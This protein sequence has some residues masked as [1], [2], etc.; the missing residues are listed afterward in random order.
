M[1]T[2]TR[3]FFHAAR[4]RNADAGG[5]EGSG[6]APL[7]VSIGELA[8][9][10]NSPGYQAKLAAE[11]KAAAAAKSGQDARAPGN[12]GILPAGNGVDPDAA[13]ADD[14]I[15]ANPG[16]QITGESDA[17]AAGEPPAL[18]VETPAQ[19]LA[20][21]EAE[22]K[23]LE[24]GEAAAETDPVLAKIT[25]LEAEV[26]ALKAGKPV[27]E[28]T[29]PSAPAQGRFKSDAEI[30]AHEDKLYYTLD[31]AE[32]HADGFEGKD[33]K[34]NPLSYTAEQI[35]A[36]AREAKRELRALPAE[37][38]ALATT[39]AIGAANRAKYPTHFN[40]AHPD[41]KAVAALFLERPAIKG[42]HELAAQI[43]AGRKAVK[44]APAAA[45][46]KTTVPPKVTAPVSAGS[47]ARPA[48]TKPGKAVVDLDK[49]R[50]GQGGLG[51]LVM[52]SMRRRTA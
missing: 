6:D 22:K 23:A 13:G 34:G 21:L 1:N 26:A 3:F 29:V 52:Q 42:D 36:W 44:G 19:K 14:D 28:S 15:E 37:R 30:K 4:L 49:L 46:A 16:E 51:S 50:T 39:K 43:L 25:A 31:F 20:R 8:S 7:K 41:S 27:D 10:K 47:P 40:A 18:P 32:E 38:E 2:T 12:A 24:G 11:A 33:D 45:P 5:G 9:L 17:D 35:K 48:V